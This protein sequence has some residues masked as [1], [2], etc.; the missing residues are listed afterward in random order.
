VGCGA[1][2]GGMERAARLI[3]YFGAALVIALSAYALL[4]S[5]KYDGPRM[6][7]EQ[8]LRF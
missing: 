8:K 1:K 6:P 4:A 3:A 2:A 7:H 5:I